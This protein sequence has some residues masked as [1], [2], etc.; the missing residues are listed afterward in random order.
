MTNTRKDIATLIKAIQKNHS[1]IDSIRPSMLESVI[2]EIII[3]NNKIIDIQRKAFKGVDYIAQF[4]DKLNHIHSF[5]VEVRKMTRMIDYEP[6]RQFQQN[7]SSLTHNLA[8][9][10]F[11]TNSVFTEAAKR[12]AESHK[13]TIELIDRSCLQHLIDQYETNRLFFSERLFKQLNNINLRHLLDI[14]DPSPEQ[15]EQ[16]QPETTQLSKPQKIALITVDF[17]PL[18]LLSKILRAPHEVRNLSPRQFEEFIAETLSQLGFKDVILTPRSHD[19]G[20]DVIASHQINGIPLSFYFE[21]KQYSKGN[22]IQLKTLR[23]L[24]GT[25]AHDRQNV[26]KGVLVTTSTFTKGSKEF[27]LSEARLDGKDYDG[28][29]GWI[30]EMKKKI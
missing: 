15:I 23:A 1:L 4:I 24:L 8:K 20:K 22:K 16:I 27:I 26:N 19:G 11:V 7:I 6:I 2:A 3:Q 30:E 14:I 29:L 12:L 9:S 5:A 13:N 18:K 25:L 17:L 21:C 10:Y 28:I